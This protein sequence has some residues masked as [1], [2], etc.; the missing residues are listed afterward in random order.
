MHTRRSFLRTSLAA[1]TAI[2]ADVS[3]IAA[4][5][6]PA[7]PSISKSPSDAYVNGVKFV[8]PGAPDYASAREVYNAGILTQPK[9][10]ASCVSETGVQRA[11]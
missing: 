2:L 6:R 5:E 1:T 7:A 11:L 3:S 8:V 10:I 9:I 4:K